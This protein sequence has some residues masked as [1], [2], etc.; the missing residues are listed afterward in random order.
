ML[1]TSYEAIKFQRLDLFTVTIKQIGTNIAKIQ[2][3]DAID[4]LIDGD[5]NNNS[6]EDINTTTSG[7]LTYADLL[8]LWALFEKHELNVLLAS[9]NSILK[10][11]K[12]SE[13]QNPL[14]GLNFA[15]TGKL[16]TP[17][18]ADLYKSNKIPDD[19][20]IGLDRKCALEKIECGNINIDYDRI[21]DRQLERAAIT[22][23]AGFAKIFDDA[24]K[25]LII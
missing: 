8:S 17:L 20:I 22:S 12:L 6:I 21:I 23:I 19:I 7:T 24:S 15:G 14:T 2:L 16:S 13:F 4:V 5:G 11:A 10:M 9:P 18:G 25:M 1:V 3:Q